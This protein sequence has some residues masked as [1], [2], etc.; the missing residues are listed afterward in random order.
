MSY[1]MTV[2]ASSPIL[3]LDLEE[4]SGTIAI[5]SSGRQPNAIYSA[6]PSVFYNPLVTNGIRSQQFAGARNVLGSLPLT[7]LSAEQPSAP[8]SL[9]AWTYPQISTSSQRVI[10]R[11]VSGLYVDGNIATFQIQTSAGVEKVSFPLRY[12]K[13]NHL[14]GVF[15]G[16]AA[17]LYVNNQLSGFTL[18]EGTISE[19]TT[20]ILVGGTAAGTDSVFISNV[21]VYDTALSGSVIE[22]HYE[23]GCVQ[24]YEDQLRRAASIFYDLSDAY[25]IIAFQSIENEFTDYSS[26]SLVNIVYDTS[27]HQEDITQVGQRDVG[28]DIG[29]LG[30]IDGSRIDWDS[31]SANLLVEVSWDNGTTWEAVTNHSTIPGLESGV[32]TTDKVVRFRQTFNIP[33]DDDIPSITEFKIT[34]YENKDILAVNNSARAVVIEPVE[35]GQFSNNVLDG[36]DSDIAIVGG[37]LTLPADLDG[38]NVAAIEFLVR[39]DTAATDIV[40]AGTATLSSSGAVSGMAVWIDGVQRA[41]VAA[42][43]AL[44]KW[45]HIYAELTAPADIDVILQGGNSFAFPAIYWQP[46]SE[47]VIFNHALGAWGRPRLAVPE[48]S[49][50]QLTESSAIAYKYVWTGA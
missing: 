37:S 32:D 40:T 5:D 46:L 25:S 39:R 28:Y 13:V 50:P 29:E 41:P 27:L 7:I 15:D 8:F 42:D 33:A 4:S 26:S 43:F 44:G 45:T 2:L 9:E 23:Q 47:S 19:D 21:A 34:I 17:A 12:R 35:I 6:P 10:G 36:N 38:N 3:Y 24:N 18:L 16:A 1:R 49:V 48:L 22:D 11:N 14:V 30:I 31:Q 20:D